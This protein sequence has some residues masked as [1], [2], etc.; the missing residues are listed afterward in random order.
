MTPLSLS[1]LGYGTLTALCIWI[2]VG[3]TRRTGGS[4]GEPGSEPADVS[5]R[6]EQVHDESGDGHDQRSQGAT[7]RPVKWPTSAPTGV[8]TTEANA[9]MKP[10][11]ASV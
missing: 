7:L 8:S 11:T 5:R 1:Y 6:D 9:A 10:A 2:S 3:T 4:V